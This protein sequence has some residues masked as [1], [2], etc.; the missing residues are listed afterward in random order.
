MYYF[1]G[2]LYLF[3]LLRYCKYTILKKKCTTCVFNRK[4]REL[5]IDKFKI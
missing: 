5:K 2:S 4:Q 1:H 3:T